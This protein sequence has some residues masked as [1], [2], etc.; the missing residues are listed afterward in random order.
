MGFRS[1]IELDHDSVLFDQPDALIEELRRYAASGQRDGSGLPMWGLNPIAMRHSSEVYYISAR[2]RGFPARL[3]Y[4]EAKAAQA[5]VLARA[6]EIIGPS[7]RPSL[8]SKIGLMVMI[9]QLVEI[10][11]AE[12]VE[13]D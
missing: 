5:T 10:I 11:E 4:E 3:P 6:K 9:E 2:M 7:D 13:E 1:L 12:R 8:A